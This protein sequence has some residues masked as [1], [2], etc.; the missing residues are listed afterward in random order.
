MILEITENQ[1]GERID[2]FL[3]DSQDLTRFLPS[4]NT[5]GRRGYSKWEKR[6][7]KL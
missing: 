3:A 1:A 2:R 5:E 4:E 6:K 7:G